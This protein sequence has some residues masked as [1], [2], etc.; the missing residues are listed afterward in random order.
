MKKPQHRRL[1]VSELY[2]HP[3]TAQLAVKYLGMTPIEAKDGTLIDPAPDDIMSL[4]AS[5]PTISDSVAIEMLDRPATIASALLAV[6]AKKVLTLADAAGWTLFKPASDTRTVYVSTSGS[7]SNDGSLLKPVK[8]L[9]AGTALLRDGYP[10]WLLLEAG[11]TWRESFPGWWKS[12]RSSSQKMRIGMYGTGPRPIVI[13]TTESAIYGWTGVPR[14]FLHFGDIDFRCEGD[15]INGTPSAILLLGN[16]HDVTY[17]GCTAERYFVA[18]GV[19]AD[20]AQGMAKEIK[21]FRCGVRESWRLSS[22]GHCQAFF[23][24]GVDG[25][26]QIESVG[27]HC[28]WARNVTSQPCTVFRHFKYQQYDCLRTLNVNPIFGL[29]LSDGMQARGPGNVDGGLGLQ[30]AI[31]CIKGFGGTVKN[32]VALDS[33]DIDD[34][35]WI[36]TASKNPGLGRGCAVEFSGGSNGVIDNCL[37]AYRLR[38][39]QYNL[40]PFGF[41]NNS[42]NGIVRNSRSF[43]WPGDS[44]CYVGSGCTVTV[45]PSNKFNVTPAEVRNIGT[46]LTSKGITFAPGTGVDVYL[47]LAMKL[48]DRTAR[49]ER[50]A[51]KAVTD[52]IRGGFAMAAIG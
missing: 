14:G 9:A 27:D 2:K 31:H 42:T 52:Y 39:Y 35:P 8:T 50:F 18:F 16:W 20:P 15:G 30:N 33:R 23:F 32:F 24:A 11:K 34:V 43:G 7:D 6:D 21:T 29:T 47:A 22:D 5:A 37:A 40:T 28:G 13:S 1:L 36:P 25:L 19:S 38:P 48:C 44:L 51:Y 3:A 4:E 10:D 49:D 26:Q 17:E 12:G 41:D 46:F 45:D